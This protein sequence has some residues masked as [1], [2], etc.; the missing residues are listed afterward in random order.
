MTMT[1]TM[2]TKTLMKSKAAPETTQ[3]AM[4]ASAAMMNSTAALALM[5]LTAAAATAAMTAVPAKMLMLVVKS[6]M[7]AAAD[8]TAHS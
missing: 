4:T 7:V 6:S 1:T 8:L 5:K 3:I 2:T